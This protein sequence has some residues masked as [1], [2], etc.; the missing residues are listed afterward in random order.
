MGIAFPWT[1]LQLTIEWN[2]QNTKR[3]TVDH[4]EETRKPRRDHANLVIKPLLRSLYLS[5]CTEASPEEIDLASKKSE[6]VRRQRNETLTDMKNEKF[7]IILESAK[8]KATRLLSRTIH[9]MNSISNSLGGVA[10]TL[11]GSSGRSSKVVRTSQRS[12]RP[13]S[14][15]TS[16]RI[17]ASFHGEVAAINVA[18]VSRR[19]SSVN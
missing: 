7:N 15:H 9:P 10:A 16:H 13:S 3:D 6:D 5:H 14:T 12:S 2:P 4:F 1:C 17:P 8:R 19:A 11:A 18:S